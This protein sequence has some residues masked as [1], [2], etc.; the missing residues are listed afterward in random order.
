VS[1]DLAPEL[2]P[3][4][5][6]RIQ[7]QQVL[8]NLLI[9]ACDAMDHGARADTHIIVRSAP[10]GSVVEVSVADRGRG[11]PPG[12]MERVFEPFVTTKAQGLGLGLAVCRTIVAAHG[13]RIWASNNAGGGATIHFTLPA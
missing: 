7:L 4:R 12:E 5:G 13:G 3:V 10:A 11:I 9:N 2:P 6:D 1:T 8:L